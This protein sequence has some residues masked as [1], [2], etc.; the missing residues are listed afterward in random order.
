LDV[1]LSGVTVFL[2]GQVLVRF[3]L[4]PLHRLKEVKGEIASTLLFH[5]NNYGQQYQ[6][7]D[8]PTGDTDADARTINERIESA[9]MWNNDLSKAS[10]ETRSMAAKLV[11]AAE[12]IPFY[13]LLTRCRV[14]PP[15]SSILQAKAHLIGLSNSFAPNQFDVCAKNSIKICQ[16]LGIKFVEE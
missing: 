4:G 1:I 9:K 16:L 15:K 3:F 10:D 12:S 2:I 6:K 7:L 5:A 14:V 13:G 11:S 8:Q